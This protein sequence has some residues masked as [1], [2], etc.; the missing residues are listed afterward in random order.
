MGTTEVEKIKLL[1]QIARSLGDVLTNEPVPE[2]V[3]IL[4]A[5]DSGKILIVLADIIDAMLDDCN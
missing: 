3:K 4:S 1:V 2:R 5:T